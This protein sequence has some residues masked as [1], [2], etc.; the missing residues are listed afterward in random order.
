MTLAFG[1]QMLAI[2][3]P[4]PAPER[5]LRAMH[6][7]SPNIYDGELVDMMPDLMDDL[8]T[9]A[10]TKHDVALYISNGHGAWEAALSNVFS[11]G[12]HVLVLATGRFAQGWR[13]MTEQMGITTDMIDFGTDCPID[14]ARVVEA[15]NADN[16]RIKAVL[17][18]HTD[19]ASSVRNDIAALGKAIQSTGHDALFMVDCIASL[20]C[21]PFEM[22]AWGVD[23]MVTGCQKGLMTPAGMSFV[24]FG[25]RA[26][27]RAETADCRTG[28]WNW[29]PRADPAMFYQRFCG[30]APTHHLFG[31]RE[32][33]TML[34][35]EEGVQA[36]WARH[37]VL[38]SAVWAAADRW[39]E[40]GALRPNVPDRAHRSLAVTTLQLEGYD[41]EALR[42]WC[43]TKAGV[44]LGV[45]LGLDF[46][47]ARGTGLFRIGH[48]GHLNA[49]SILGTLA[50]VEA[51]L[52]ALGIPHGSGGIEAAVTAIAEA[53][54]A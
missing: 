39:A 50:C 46:T 3:G 36:A 44:T 49:H 23:V 53:V 15:L 47:Q 5:V 45:G 19:T 35:H 7:G 25:P 48:M 42:Q 33:L 32:A 1:Q 11:R 29:T 38:A 30:T 37:A 8:R 22:D 54:G 16:G 9:V 12:D 51:G 6:R 28:Y 27:A 4:S 17:C 34:V 10:R 41:V 26:K 2:P 18:V 24:F 52:K 14:P 31:L 13:E 20:G 43:E 21:E 40:G